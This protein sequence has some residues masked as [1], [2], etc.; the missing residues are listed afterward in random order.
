M[1][2]RLSFRAGYWT[3]IVPNGQAIM[4]FACLADAITMLTDCLV[5]RRKGYQS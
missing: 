1:K 5:E 2:V 4:T 3:L